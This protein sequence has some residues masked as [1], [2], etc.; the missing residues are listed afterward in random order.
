VFEDLNAAQSKYAI[1]TGRDLKVTRAALVQMFLDPKK[2]AEEL[3]RQ[4][5]KLTDSQKQQIDTLVDQNRADEAQVLLAK[6]LR[7]EVEGLGGQLAGL[8]GIWARLQS[9]ASQAGHAMEASVRTRAHW[10]PCRPW[11]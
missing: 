11:G 5:G 9:A 1:A 4:F 3:Q 10:P 8:A 6:R 2:G 7:E